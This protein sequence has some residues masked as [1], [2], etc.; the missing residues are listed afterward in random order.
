MG[1][2][3]GYQ[4]AEKT[5][6]L[7]FERRRLT[8]LKRRS[9][10]IQQS[11]SVRGDSRD[12]GAGVCHRHS[13]IGATALRAETLRAP[14]Y[15]H[16]AHHG[17]GPQIIVH[18]QENGDRADPGLRLGTRGGVAPS[19]WEPARRCGSLYRRGRGC[20][21]GRGRSVWRHGGALRVPVQPDAELHIRRRADLRHM[22]AR[23]LRRSMR[24][25]QWPDRRSRRWAALSEG[26][27]PPSP[28]TELLPAIP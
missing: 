25:G 4:G 12:D 27:R 14:R 16:Y 13:G 19:W 24:P 7:N 20:G 8:K 17:Q 21:R 9:Y 15:R 3:S 1:A 5:R 11:F 10:S 6:K 23:S 18:P 2:R 28:A 22:A 26:P